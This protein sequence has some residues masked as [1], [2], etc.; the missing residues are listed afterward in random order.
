MAITF[1]RWA[2]TWD[3]SNPD[4]SRY[5]GAYATCFGNIRVGG[6]NGAS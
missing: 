3:G 6:S 4:T 2:I 5:E 1:R